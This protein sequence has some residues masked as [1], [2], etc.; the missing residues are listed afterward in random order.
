MKKLITL[1]ALLGTVFLL[2][3]CGSSEEKADDGKDLETTNTSVLE[4]N[5]EEK[6]DFI[7]L[8]KKHIEEFYNINGVDVAMDVNPFWM[9][10]DK[11]ADTGEEY[12][13]ILSGNSTFKYDG[14]TYKYVFIYSKKDEK[15]YTVLYLTSDY[16]SNEIS[17]PLESD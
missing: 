9:P 4:T 11:N 17:V 13:N 10:D 2:V 1:F 3:A 12:K 5:N 8:A 16:S 14:N 6:A 7:T 15:N